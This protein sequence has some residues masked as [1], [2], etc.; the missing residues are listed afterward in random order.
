M[1]TSRIPAIGFGLELVIVFVLLATGVS[2]EA[3]LRIQRAYCGAKD[4]WCDVTAYLQSKVHD[5]T[6]STKISQPF[7]EIGG[8][9][10]PGQVK[11]LIIDYRLNGASFRLVLKEQGPLAFTVELPSSEAVAPGADPEATALMKDAKSHIRG[12]HSWLVY[13]GY[14][15]TIVSVIWAVVAT[16]QLCKVKNQLIKGI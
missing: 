7:R 12:G 11:H 4:S 5:D 8:D 15:I 6:L 14:S 16:I 9:P 3:A 13:L 2:A 10:A 1:K